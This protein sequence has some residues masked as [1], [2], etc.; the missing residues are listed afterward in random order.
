MSVVNFMKYL[1]NLLHKFCLLFYTSKSNTV[2]QKLKIHHST[3]I[4]SLKDLNKLGLNLKP[5]TDKMV[6]KESL[7]YASQLPAHIFPWALRLK[8]VYQ[9]TFKP[10]VLSQIKSG[11]LSASGGVARNASGQIAAIGTNINPLLV[12]PPAILYQIGVIVFG[13]YYLKSINQS[14][15]NINK[16]LDKISKFQYD[17]RSAQINSYLQE[18]HH[19]SQG[20]IDF[21][22]SGNT[23]Q[24]LNRIKRM[25]GIRM[26]NSTPLLHLQQNIVDQEDQLKNLNRSSWFKSTTEFHKLENLIADHVRN[27]EDYQK[28]LILD[29]F[30][31]KVEV[32]FSLCRSRMEIESRLSAQEENITFLKSNVKSFDRVLNKKIPALIEKKWFLSESDIKK[33][34]E[35][36]SFWDPVKEKTSQF[37]EEC[38]KHVQSTKSV[39]NSDG[40]SVFY[41]KNC[42]KIHEYKK[43]A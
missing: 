37:E 14:L 19:L 41:L 16:K 7:I 6:N 22:Q 12:F 33:R 2:A 15:K 29:I 4:P 36:R 21:N 24:V 9:V 1:K 23:S 32:R 17:K 40:H 43:S 39:I 18:F 8:G 10:E 27:I 3:D 35:L 25:Q 38:K 30:L 13:S 26:Q 5:V 20:I 28:S 34:K 11:A 42:P 31:T